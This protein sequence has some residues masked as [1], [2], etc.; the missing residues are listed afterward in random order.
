MEADLGCHHKGLLSHDI[1][2]VQGRRPPKRE[3]V[4]RF[5]PGPGLAAPPRT[6][7]PWSRYE[8]QSTYLPQ[9]SVK[10]QTITT[11]L[12]GGLDHSGWSVGMLSQKSCP[13]SAD[14]C[15][16]GSNTWEIER[17]IFLQ[18]EKIRHI[19]NFREQLAGIHPRRTHAETLLQTDAGE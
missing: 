1:E 19:L 16:Q 7:E 6:T 14:P 4:D 11:K 12:L 10:H 9:H 13:G 3:Q 2:R 8:Q 5:M 18:N 17:Q 15:V